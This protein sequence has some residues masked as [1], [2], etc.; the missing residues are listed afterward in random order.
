MGD[1]DWISDLCAD[2]N[3]DSKGQVH[4]ISDSNEDCQ[5]TDYRAFMLYS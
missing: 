2:R 3:V 1:S 4:E 5:E